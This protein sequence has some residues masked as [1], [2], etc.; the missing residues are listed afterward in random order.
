MEKVTIK[1]IARLTGLS[2]GTV[3]RVLHN[4]E[5]VSRKSYAKVMKVIE[6]L[7]YE[8]NIY[9]SLLAR[10]ETRV[11]AVILPHSAPGEFWEL[12]EPGLEKAAGDA[13]KLGVEVRK[14]EYDQYDEA[15]FIAACDQAL[16]LSPSGIVLPPMFRDATLAFTARLREAGIPYVFIDTKPEGDDG[17]LAYYG[18]P[19][20]Q[21]GYLCAA[22]L[23]D[24]RPIDAIGV[25]RI[26]RDKLGLSDPT[27][28]RREGFIDYIHKFYPACS[29]DFVFIDP[30]KPAEVDGILEEF[31][32]A[33]PGISE[34][35]MYNS[36]IYLIAPFLKRHADR[37]FRV[38]GFDALAANV[39]LLED[40]T[41]KSLIAQ[42]PDVQLAE[43]IA[44]LTDLLVFGKT[45]SVR[46]N[47]SHME[48][49][50]RYNI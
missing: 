47:F 48:I 17:Y 15:A 18:M 5:G 43:A 32:A 12:V 9:A 41:V 36:R 28:S 21:S 6:D 42:H 45:P 7:G 19:T 26:Q 33:H 20:Y 30:N 50:T 44:A 35:A 31:F 22:L 29:M 13:R 8:P 14:I 39:A 40:G 38:V 34:I 23:T 37:H 24:D 1:D 10:H 46:D 3:D 16:A 4:R 27:I 2:K 25:I 49:L 11:V